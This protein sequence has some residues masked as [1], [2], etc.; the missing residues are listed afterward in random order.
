MMMPAFAAFGG[1]ILLLTLFLQELQGYSPLQAGLIQAP[2]T[3]GTAISL[4]LASRHLPALG[5]RRMMIVGFLLLG[6]D[7][8]C[9]S[10]R[11]SSTRPWW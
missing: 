1:F 2:S 6:A 4:P 11:C 8:C 10:L 7:R 9:R 5:P 3:L